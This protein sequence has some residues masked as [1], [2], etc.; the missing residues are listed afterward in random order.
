MTR[1]Y[2]WLIIGL[3]DKSHRVMNDKKHGY[4]AKA[5]GL[6]LVRI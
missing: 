1:I 3:Y 5:I 4:E 2:D 6:Q